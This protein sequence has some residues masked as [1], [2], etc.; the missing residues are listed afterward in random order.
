MAKKTVIVGSGPAGIAAML[1][2]IRQGVKPLILDVGWQPDSQSES[3]SENFYKFR[4]SNDSH[5]LMIGDQFQGL[6]N[7][8]NHQS[9]PPKL[10]APKMDF[11]RK[12][13]EQL[14]PIDS[15]NFTCIQSFAA[16]G[17]AS[18]WGAGV[19]R[20]TA[21][22]L[23]NLPIDCHDLNPYYDAL[24]E[25]IGICGKSDD[26]ANYFGSDHALLP[27]LELSSKA[28]HFYA[29]Y[30][31]KKHTLNQQ[32]MFAGAPRL[33]VLSKQ[34]DGRQECDYT[35]LEMWQPNLPYLYSPAFTL[36]K[37]IQ[38]GQAEY[39]HGLFVRHWQYQGDQ[40]VIA[41]E[42]I[43]SQQMEF[44]RADTLILA[45]GTVNT[46]RIVL[47]SRRHF[48][49]PL[50]LIDNPLVQIPLL[51]FSFLG[52]ALEIDAFGMTQLNTVFDFKDLNLLLQGSIIE[53]TA[54][55]R[56]VFFEQ[57]PFSASANLT[58][59][60]LITPAIMV[61]FLYF[62][63]SK[64]NTAQLSLNQNGI[65][66]IHAPEFSFNSRAMRRAAKLLRKAGAFTHP[67]LMQYAKAGY[68]IHYAGTLPMKQNPDDAFCC[69]TD[70]LLYGEKN[71]YVADGSL[72][73][74]IAAKNSS[75][76]VMANAMRIADM[77][78][79]KKS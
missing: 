42:N 63:S 69:G 24:S 49:K 19:Y 20:Y 16:G 33:A 12:N 31:K 27:S 77:I 8:L 79:R 23:K 26:L 25:E 53:L 51:F 61:L 65:M 39:R 29:N 37:Y 45:A 14:S 55:A 72:F 70:G 1:G 18:A 57:F 50:P 36:K 38:S 59:M 22:E 60:R 40:L 43:H 46:A 78:G 11:T 58:A 4:Q 56:A 44:I 32:G 6:T 71:I 15:K 74:E 9:L 73:S 10:I 75:F 41:A 66:H 3:V 52:S 34:F 68:A 7:V 28:G 17:L 67:K 21:A 47:A 62:P 48:E 76:T 64:V 5:H 2:L 54:P 35:N 13:T 30:Q